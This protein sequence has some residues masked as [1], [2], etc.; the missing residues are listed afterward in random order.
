MN[1]IEHMITPAVIM[2]LGRGYEILDDAN[3]KHKLTPESAVRAHAAGN[4]YAANPTANPLYLFSGRYG[5]VASRGKMPEPPEGVSEGGMQKEA[6]MDDV[7][8]T[9][10]VLEFRGSVQLVLPRA[11]VE[12]KSVCTFT[13]FTE[14]IDVGWLAPDMFTPENPL[15]LSTS[16]VHSW[17]SSVIGARAL[18]LGQDSLYRLPDYGR[19]KGLRASAKERIL[20][21]VTRL[22]LAQ[23]GETSGAEPGNLEHIK[24]A[25]QAFEAMSLSPRG[26]LLELARHPRFMEVSEVPV[27]PDELLGMPA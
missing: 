4:Y 2:T 8:Q 17:R 7:H 14:S 25:A 22:A 24:A 3:T 5:R 19:E 10:N 13:N 1:R 27:L 23:V 26:A 6:F 18:A 21:G 9:M 20:L 15:V 16:R 12:D 11:V